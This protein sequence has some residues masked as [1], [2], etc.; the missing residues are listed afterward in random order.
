[1]CRLKG[2]EREWVVMF[3]SKNE[4]FDRRFEECVGV[5]VRKE[6]GVGDEVNGGR[7]V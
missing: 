4:W 3:G 7:G 1:M 2:G 6:D 5:S